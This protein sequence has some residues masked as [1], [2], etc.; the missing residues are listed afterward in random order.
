MPRILHRTYR[1]IDA[2]PRVLGL[3]PGQW[4][5]AL[6]A[7]VILWGCLQ[8]GFLPLKYRLSVGIFVGG[9]PLGL[10]Y[11]GAGQRAVL[12]LPRR[13]GHFLLAPRERT[14]GPP[15]RGPLSFELYDGRPADEEDLPDA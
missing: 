5:L 8:V 6:L 9:L 11:S 1:Q 12:E 2:P 13:L 10:S 7:L 14:P 3:T 15:R 4:L